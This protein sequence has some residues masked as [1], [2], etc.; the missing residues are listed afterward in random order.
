MVEVACDLATMRA[1]GMAGV[2]LDKVDINA[3]A[4]EVLECTV[5]GAIVAIL[6]LLATV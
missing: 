2:R 5:F 3:R 6:M 1:A 4:W